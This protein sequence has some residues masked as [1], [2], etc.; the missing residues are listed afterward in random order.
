[1]AGT[2]KRDPNPGLPLARAQLRAAA[3]LFGRVSEYAKHDSNPG[4]QNAVDDSEKTLLQAAI[5]YAVL[6]VADWLHERGDRTSSIIMHRAY[7]R[8]AGEV[9][10]RKWFE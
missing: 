4:A 2:P 7:A 10:T 8:L 6:R 5:D 9:I 3:E 1:M